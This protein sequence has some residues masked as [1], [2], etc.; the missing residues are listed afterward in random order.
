MI[1]YFPDPSDNAMPYIMT[2]LSPDTLYTVSAIA[3]RPTVEVK[4][5][6]L[7]FTTSC[8]GKIIYGEAKMI[9][10]RMLQCTSHEA[11]Y[12]YIVHSSHV[13]N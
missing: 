8:L 4:F 10:K 12:G 1:N 5:P 3:S 6:E 11:L 13:T 2:Q 9:L 7:N